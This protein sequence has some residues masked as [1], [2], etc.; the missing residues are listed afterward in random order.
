MID[1]DCSV[2]PFAAKCPKQDN[3]ERI[4]WS[5]GGLV[6]APKLKSDGRNQ[7]AKPAISLARSEVGAVQKSETTEP[8]R[9]FSMSRL[10]RTLKGA[11]KT[12]HL[13]NK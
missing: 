10:Y 1:T 11:R 3:P 7:P 5:Q 13:W 8:A 2:C 9:C 12:A 6:Y 4:P